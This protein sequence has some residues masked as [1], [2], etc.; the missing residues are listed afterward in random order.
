MRKEA[1]KA[2]TGTAALGWTWAGGSVRGSVHRSPASP[3]LGTASST[4]T[5]CIV[6]RHWQMPALLAG[7][8]SHSFASV[9]NRG[10]GWAS[11]NVPMLPGIRDCVTE[12]YMATGSNKC[13]IPSPAAAPSRSKPWPSSRN[14]RSLVG[15]RDLDTTG[16]EKCSLL[17]TVSLSWSNPN[18]SAFLY[19][20]ESSLNLGCFPPKSR[21]LLHY[22]CGCCHP[23][24]LLH[25]AIPSAASPHTLLLYFWIVQLG[26]WSF[27][28][29]LKNSKGIEAGAYNIPAHESNQIIGMVGWALKLAQFKPE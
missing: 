2:H 5:A 28:F 4:P 21:L 24:T 17:L 15:C 29:L 10:L 14:N 7:R 27:L 6:S 16:G 9:G 23:A 25:Y 13:C 3:G 20:P 1:R 19:H 22:I 8:T 12:G 11:R 26:L 18:S